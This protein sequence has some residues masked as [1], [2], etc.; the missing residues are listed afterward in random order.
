MIWLCHETRYVK[1]AGFGHVTIKCMNALMLQ[2]FVFINDYYDY[3][4]T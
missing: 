2:A 4:M 1:Q 3:G